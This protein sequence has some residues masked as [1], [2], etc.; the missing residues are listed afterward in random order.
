MTPNQAPDQLPTISEQMAEQLGG[1]RGLVE[2]SL[3]VAVFVV[4]NV[5]WGL[6]PALLCAVGFAVAL[7]GWRLSQRRPTRHALNGMV[8]VGI[9]AAFA[10]NTGEAKDFYLPGILYGI[11]Y[12]FALMGSI[13]IRRP[14]VG[15]LWSIIVDGGRQQWRLDPRLLRTF[16]WLTALWATVYLAKAGLQAWIFY[17]GLDD[18][19]KATTLGVIRIALGFP[20]YALLLGLTVW[21]VRRVLREPVHTAVAA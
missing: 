4:A 11:G 13:V 2:S 21:T 14:L 7:A 18:E 1:W 9:G 16:G 5:V 12:S 3:P 17:S 20:P 6:R 8:G 15:W 10:W 19:T